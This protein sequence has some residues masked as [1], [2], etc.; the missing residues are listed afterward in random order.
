MTY[1][2]ELP[3]ST[4]EAQGV[5]SSG[6]QAFIDVLEQKRLG[7]HSFVLV[8]N[9]HILADGWWNPYTFHLPHSMFSVSKSFTSTA[10]GL[11]IAE[12][13]LSLDDPILSFFPA[14]ITP[15]ISENM[16]PVQIR[17]LLSMS[18]GHAEDTIGAV[19][20]PSNEDWV[21]TFLSLPITH[22]PGTHFI[23]NSGASFMLSAILQ[24][25]TGQTLVE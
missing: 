4:P 25:L 23:Y 18:T 21:R 17:H 1:A 2:S 10:I 7:V 6:I 5:A 8:R 14:Y 13:R 16:G 12:G 22:A 15:E 9:A 20:R 11:A 24:S 19:G 3:R